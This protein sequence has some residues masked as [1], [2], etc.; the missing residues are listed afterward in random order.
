M[1]SLQPRYRRCRV[2][3]LKLVRWR[4]TVAGP[5]GDRGVPL[6]AGRSRNFARFCCCPTHHRKRVTL[7]PSVTGK[8]LIAALRRMGFAVARIE[9]SHH[10][11]RQ[12]D[13]RITVVPVHAGETIGAGLPSRMLRDGT[14]SREQLHALL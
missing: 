9:G 7:Y 2:A 8:V 3:T 1:A 12:P 14:L 5:R 6:G 11:M 13:G 4:A 10:S